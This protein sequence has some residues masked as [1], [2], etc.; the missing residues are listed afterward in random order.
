MNV[1]VLNSAVSAC[2][3]GSEWASALSLVVG[4]WKVD[5]D[6]VSYNSVV[7]GMATERLW[8]MAVAVLELAREGLLQLDERSYT[9]LLQAAAGSWQLGL[10]ILQQMRDE[11]VPV[12]AFACAAAVSSCV[13]SKNWD[14]AL[15]LLSESRCLQMKSTSESKENWQVPI[16]SAIDVCGSALQWREVLTLLSDM[17]DAS[18]LPSVVT[19]GAAMSSLE[20]SGLWPKVLE[21]W[22]TMQKWG[23]EANVYVYSTAM[24][25]LEKAELWHEVLQIFEEMKTSN[26]RPSSV[27]YNPLLRSCG[28]EGG[29]PKALFLVS[30]MQRDGVPVTVKTMNALLTV[31]QDANLWAL[32]L[33]MLRPWFMS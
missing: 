32:S 31:L 4:R 13:E 8:E 20:R 21:I 30:E 19:C 15:N 25:S 6:I 14:L 28:H 18:M 33:H 27:S 29:W 5:P 1:V 11:T 10:S 22:E 9:S 2:Q 7:S 23:V 3:R 24:S 16:L 26:V 17:L 12:G